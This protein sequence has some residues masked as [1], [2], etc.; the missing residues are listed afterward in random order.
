[1]SYHASSLD[2]L[3]TQISSYYSFSMNPGRLRGD[4][5]FDESRS[6]IRLPNPVANQVKWIC[7]SEFWRFVEQAPWLITI[8]KRCFCF[9]QRFPKIKW[10]WLGPRVVVMC[11]IMSLISLPQTLW[12]PAKHTHANTHTHTQTHTHTHISNDCAKGNLLL[13]CVHDCVLFIVKYVHILCALCL[14]D[15]AM[16]SILRVLWVCYICGGVNVT[17][18]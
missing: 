16:C 8:V 17:P 3:R 5:E 13:C 7:D 6:G 14:M 4:I 11:V 12:L 9:C 18:T 15:A 10:C 2:L 1:M